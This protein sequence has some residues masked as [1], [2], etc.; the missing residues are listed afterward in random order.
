MVHLLCARVQTDKQIGRDVHFHL[1]QR[2]TESIS[3]SS[4]MLVSHSA[5]PVYNEQLLFYSS[6]YAVRLFV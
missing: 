2:R 6:G 3:A 1:K 4:I 5:I